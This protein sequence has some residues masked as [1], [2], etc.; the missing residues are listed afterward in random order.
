MRA[1]RVAVRTFRDPT[2]A[3]VPP[4]HFY[5]PVPG[6]ADREAAI[7]ALDWHPTSLPGVDLNTEGQMAL[8]ERLRGWYD[9]LPFS[10]EADG[11]HRYR[12]ANPTYS[13]ADGIIYACLLQELR[14]TRVVEVGSGWSSALLLDINEVRLGGGTD[15]TFVEPF[16]EL[17]GQ[18]T[19][20]GDLDGRLRQA[21]LQ[22]MPHDL[23]TA[24]DD[25]DILF[26][27]STHVARTGS[28]VNFL[29][30]E[31][32]PRLRH[33]VYVHF[34]D[35]FYP[36]EY[37]A[38]WLLEGCSWN[39][40]Y[41]LRAFL[42]FNSAFKIELFATYIEHEREDWFAEHMPKCLMNPG[43]NIWLRRID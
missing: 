1:A 8:L 14:P 17:L 30:F 42:Q 22:T 24:L 20:P 31:I 9:D 21:P 34:H 7:A 18:V 11:R 26:I 29:F 5:S 35:V 32:L 19:R 43:G 25:G 10:V 15:I 38:Q 36:F 40:D 13:Y 41:L 16:P 23:F 27:D 6:R 3:F 37:P 39:E 28:D 2:L 12:F 4:G 33:G